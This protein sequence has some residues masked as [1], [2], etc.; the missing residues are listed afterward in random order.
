VVVI[1]GFL[2]FS[3]TKVNPEAAA[4]TGVK[5]NFTDEEKT[6]NSW[7]SSITLKVASKY[8]MVFLVFLGD[9]F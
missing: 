4:N 2:L 6:E 7:W 3:G 1:N 5:T 9:W 8:Y